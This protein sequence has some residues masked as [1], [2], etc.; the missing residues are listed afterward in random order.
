MT[1]KNYSI[2]NYYD[3][4]RCKGL[5]GCIFIL[6]LVFI[7]IT[8]FVADKPKHRIS[9]TIKP[10]PSV[11]GSV[12]RLSACATSMLLSAEPNQ[13]NYTW[14]TGA[15]SSSI[16]VTTSGTYWWETIDMANNEVANGDFSSGRTGF[17][18]SYTYIAPTGRTGANGALTAEG[19]YTI[20]TNPSISHTNFASFPDHTGNTSGTRNMMVVNGAP[21]ANVTIWTQS[22]TVTP[23]TDYIFSVWFTSVNPGNPGKLNFSINGTALG[24]PIL[25]TSGTPDW[26]NF[27]V[28]WTSGNSTSA[29]I[30][31]VNQNTASSGNDFALDDIVF[32]P[33]CRNYFDVNLYTNP[34]KPSITPL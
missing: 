6:P 25:L 27:T 31:I 29:T 24:S 13:P 17:T 14:S 12:T 10:I 20:T 3:F 9:R 16:T 23:N 26:K 1:K 15:T 18:S 32:A 22:I 8:S 28:R 7:L 33:V 19:Y 34:P 30:G 5:L 11:C 4:L 21:T 2:I